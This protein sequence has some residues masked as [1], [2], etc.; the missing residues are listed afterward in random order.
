MSLMLDKEKF[1]PH[2]DLLSYDTELWRL[3]VDSGH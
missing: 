3:F 2:E 1:N